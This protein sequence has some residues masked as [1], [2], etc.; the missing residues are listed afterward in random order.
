MDFIDKTNKR[1]F[2]P[3]VYSYLQK[4]QQMLK[5]PKSENQI[6]YEEEEAKKA[7]AVEEWTAIEGVK[8]T[9]QVVVAASDDAQTVKKSDTVKVH[10]TGI[11][12]ETDKKFWST[13]DPGQKPFS[14]KAGVGQVITGW[15]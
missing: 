4:M 5:P 6:R 9:Y 11:V 12:Q 14:Y 7:K 8:T 3:G 10:A 2:K 13:K 1:D 15:D